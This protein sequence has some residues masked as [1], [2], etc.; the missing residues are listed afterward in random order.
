METS[1]HSLDEGR[2]HLHCYFSWHG[3][4]TKGVDL[5]TTDIFVFQGVRPRV[6]QNTEKRGP[7]YWMKATQQGHFYTSVM[8][9]GT[10]FAATN[11]APWAGMWTPE[12]HWIKSLWKG[13]KLTH[14][15]YMNLS[16]QYRDGHD[17][18]KACVEAVIA[19]ELSET[20]AAEKKAARELIAQRAL[21]FKP[22]PDAIQRWKQQ[23]SEP[24]ER[25]QML[26]L[27][28][29]SCTGK[30][31]LARSLFGVDCTLVVDVQHAQH[32]DLRGYRRQEHAAI[33]LD[34]VSSPK[35]ICDNKK[36]L[37]AHVDGAILGQ[38][39]TQLYTYEVFL[40]KTPLMLTTNDFDYS[41]YT[42]SQKNWIETNAVAVLV[43]E[44]VW[45]TQAIAA[46]RSPK[47]ANGRRAW[48]SPSGP[49]Q[50]RSREQV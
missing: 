45:D 4:Q 28:G 29:P 47:V 32:P 15:M 19:A 23:Y 42:E 24:L 40:W 11:Y 18:R 31:R 6:D 17:R 48:G 44:P 20:Y 12:E 49:I 43:D 8:K 14:A 30:S 21:P 5:R 46:P 34:E 10:L 38:S 1:E 50:K 35:F 9:V 33:L 37:Q 16:V 3:P 2:V 7:H 36:V 22:M 27:H 39:A 13:H 25:Y 41:A 26:V